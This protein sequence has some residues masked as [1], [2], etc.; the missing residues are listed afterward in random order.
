[1]SG[2]DIK[3]VLSYRRDDAPGTAGRIFDRLAQHYGRESVFMDIDSIPIGVDFYD[4]IKEVLHGCNALLAIIGPRWIGQRRGKPLR[5]KEETD[6]VRMEVE[7]ALQRKIPVAPVLVDGAII[8]RRDQL[9]ETLQALVRRNAASVDS[10]RDFHA[11]V[12]RLIRDLDRLLPPATDANSDVP[13]Q[14]VVDRQPEVGLNIYARREPSLREGDHL[15]RAIDGS[16]E[17]PGSDSVHTGSDAIN[18]KPAV[19]EVVP[20]P[21]PPS[22][23]TELAASAPPS[24]DAPEVIS[25]ATGENRT[26]ATRIEPPVG[27]HEQA[28]DAPLA[29]STCPTA[30]YWRDTHI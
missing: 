2:P 6:F 23:P 30:D 4:H 19:E 25:P 7:A 15:D 28:R 1:M 13:K 5:I 20:Q 17:A 14:D 12:D 21:Q 26:K 22:E 9:P 29:A 8:P 27:I 24:Q 11:H 18:K 3:I 10:G 16:A